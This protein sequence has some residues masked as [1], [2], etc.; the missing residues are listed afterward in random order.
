MPAGTASAGAAV[1]GWC[2][3]CRPAGRRPS[4]VETPALGEAAPKDG[5]QQQWRDPERVEPPPADAERLEHGSV[6]DGAEADSQRRVHGEDAETEARARPAAPRPR[7]STRPRSRRSG[8]SAPRTDTRRRHRWSA[9]VP[10][11]PLRSCS[12]PPIRAEASAVRSGRPAVRGRARQGAH[13]QTRP[14]TATP[15]TVEPV[16]V[17]DLRQGQLED[18]GS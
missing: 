11:D 5:H 14:A 9:P 7:A 12:R 4:R 6:E 8:T 16:R 17:A 10:S 3:R 1:E 15:R 2:A 18:A 13:V